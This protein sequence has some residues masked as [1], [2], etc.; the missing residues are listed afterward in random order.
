MFQVYRAL[1]ESI[2]SICN[3]APKK[4]SACVGRC[5]RAYVAVKFSSV[6]CESDG[7]LLFRSVRQKGRREAVLVFS[8]RS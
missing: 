1:S 4:S 3:V 5:G 2:V 8:K 7:P 6:I